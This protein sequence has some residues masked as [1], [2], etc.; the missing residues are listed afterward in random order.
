MLP[1][2]FWAKV[3]EDGD[4]WT[5]TGRLNEDGYGTFKLD[6]RSVGAH[7]LAYELMAAEIPPGLEIDHLCRN[8]ACVNPSHLD[9]VPHAVNVARGAAHGTFGRGNARK[10]HCPQGHVYAGENLMVEKCGTR[11]CRTCRGIS[12][13][14]VPNGT[15]TH[16]PAGHPYAGENLYLTPAGARHCRE[17]GRAVMRARYARGKAAI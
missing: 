14:P 9:P 15:K 8:R 4:C 1:Q 11:R 16:C 10:T 5:W 2:R 3:R 12:A 13:N 17:C 7:R 6:G